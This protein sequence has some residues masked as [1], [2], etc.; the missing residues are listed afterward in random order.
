VNHD[1]R[2]L[3]LFDRNADTL[4][5]GSFIQEELDKRGW[6]Q[7]DLAK[8]TGRPLQTINALVGGKKEI[9][10]ETAY[11]LAGAFGTTPDFWMAKEIAY[12]LSQVD[13]RTG[14]IT[15]RA[16]IF[17]VAPIKEMER[18]NWIRTRDSMKD[19]TAELCSFF[20]VATLADQPRLAVN[21]RAP[22]SDEGVN[23]GQLAWCYRALK[24]A[25]TIQA[26][27][28]DASR[29]P[30]LKQH[31]RNLSFIAKGV[32]DVPSILAEYGIR[33]VVVE[34]LRHSK[35]DGA[36]FWIDD[37]KPVIVL[38]MRYDRIDYFWFTLMH[39]IVHIEYRDAAPVDADIMEGSLSPIE[40]RANREGASCLIDR[41]EIQSFIRRN[42]PTFTKVGIIQFANRIKTHPGIVVGQLHFLRAWD[43]GSGR[44]MLLKVRDFLSARALSDGFGSNLPAL[45]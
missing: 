5:P 8:I 13:H 9:T 37:N 7:A 32:E 41:A 26:K 4:P 39:E 38:S 2:Q 11:D 24:L 18:R 36:A 1:P 3:Q 30:E 40:E 34:G 16:R 15:D 45:T 25:R 20:E 27:R 44:A 29:L 22:N 33:L 31:L 12:R 23:T 43:Y 17:E 28:Y 42:G 35:I 21:A 19:L 6:G 10:P 14:E